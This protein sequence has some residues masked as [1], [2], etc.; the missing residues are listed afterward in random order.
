MLKKN[1]FIYFFLFSSVNASLPFVIADSNKNNQKILLIEVEDS[2]ELLKY[3][4]ELQIQSQIIVKDYFYIAQEIPFL[5]KK[6]NIELEESIQNI[7]YILNIL[8]VSIKTKEIKNLLDYINDSNKEL[9]ILLTKKYTQ[10]N[11]S[12]ILDISESIDEA[13]REISLFLIKKGRIKN[14]LK[15]LVL[16][17]KLLLQQISKFY[18]AYQ[19]GFNDIVIL[20]KLSDALKR[21]DLNL[22]ILNAQNLNSEQKKEIKKVQHF[23]KISK[24]YYEAIKEGELSIMI[25]ISTK[26]M[27]K[28]LEKLL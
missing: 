19:A 22:K 27:I 10:N 20:E 12:E 1:I 7:Q 11:A 9:S 24:K 23:W 17:Q 21:F 13:S 2:E 3:S 28:H 14:N 8:T 16:Q 15:F 18:I 4:K 26:H 25:F 5:L 6:A